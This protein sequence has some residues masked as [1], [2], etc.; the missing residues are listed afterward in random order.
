[1]YNK[2]A[3]YIHMKAI[4]RAEKITTASAESVFTLW[5]DCEHWPLWD[6]SI[7]WAKRKAPFAA[8]S[9]YK[10]KPKGGP[11]IK[12]TILSVESHASFTDVSHLP[13][14]K[15]QFSHTL[16]KQ[17]TMTIVVHEVAVSGFLAPLWE[18]IM[19]KSLRNDLQPA[20]NK[21][22]ALAEERS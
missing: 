16:A 21:L 17:G 12:A 7:E 1:M 11:V 2:R 19:G 6:D 4:A 8:G 3:Y 15:L 5:S 18:K 22:V 10:L 20:L 14:A 13:G 9:T